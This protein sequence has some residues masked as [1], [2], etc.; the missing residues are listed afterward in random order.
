MF[1]NVE[2]DYNIPLKKQIKQYTDQ[3]YTY[4]GCFGHINAVLKFIR[5][6]N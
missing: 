4:I 3:G 6:E 1:L 5:K 2:R